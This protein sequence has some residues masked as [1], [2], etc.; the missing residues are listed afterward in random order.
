MYAECVCVP[1][2]IWRLFVAE[3]CSWMALMS[4]MFFFADFMGEALYQG[5]PSAEP[6]S[7]ERRRYDE[8]RVSTYL[9]PPTQVSLDQWDTFAV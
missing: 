8:G 7:Q 3:T 6:Q 9:A 4:V 2:V 1:A 5:V